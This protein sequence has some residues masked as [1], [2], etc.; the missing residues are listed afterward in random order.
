[1]TVPPINIGGIVI[2]FHNPIILTILGIHILAGLIC[3]ISGITG[4]DKQ[5]GTGKTSNIRFGIFLVIFSNFYHSC[6]FIN[7]TA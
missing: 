4:H 1:M 6:Y 3:L 2:P 5:K 7:H